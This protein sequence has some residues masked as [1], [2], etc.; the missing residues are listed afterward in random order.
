LL[1]KDKRVRLG[2]RS[3]KVIAVLTATAAGLNLA[4]TGE[5]AAVRASGQEPSRITA[6][7]AEALSRAAPAERIPVLVQMAQLSSSRPLSWD[8]DYRA[9]EH[10]S[11]LAELYSTSVA[12]L[13]SRL[14]AGLAADV[15]AGRVLWI[16]GSIAAQLTSS[17]VRM[18][19]SLPGVQRIHYDGL[20]EVELAADPTGLRLWAPGLPLAVQSLEGGLPWGLEAI[21]APELWAAGATGQGTVVAIIDSGV[22]GTHPLLW[23]KWRGNSTSPAEAWFDPWGLSATP[24]DDDF[25]AGAGHGTIVASIAVGSLEPGDTIQV[26][27]ERRVVQDEL[28]VVTGV[29][30]GAEWVAANG[31]EDLGGVTYTRS[32]VLLQAMQ[33]VLDPDGD[34]A[35]VSDVPDVLNNSWGFPPGGCDGPFDRAIDALEAAGV[36]V[37]FAAG[38]LSSGFQ[39]VAGPAERADLLLNAFAVGAVE[40][41]E[42]DIVVSDNSLGGPSRCAP[43]AVKPEVV[44]PGEIPVVRNFGPHMGIVLGNSGVFTSWASPHAAGALALLRGLNRA[45]GAG[46]LKAA[47]F[48]TAD[49]LPPPGLDN[50]SG[51]GLLDLVAAAEAIGGLGGVRLA[52]AHWTWDSTLAS[53]DLELHNRGRTPFPGGSAELRRGAGAST[54]AR[55]QAP[56]I[57]AQGRGRLTFSGTPDDLMSGPPPSLRLESDGAILD[58]PISL[59][60]A[61]ATAVVLE[62]GDARF[63]LDARGRLGRVAGDPGFELLGGDWL[64]AGAFLYGDGERVSDAA[65]VDVLQQPSLKQNPVG[66]DTDWHDVS[67]V[68]AGNGAEIDFSDDRALNP[69][70]ATIHQSV[71]LIAVGD[72]AAFAAL[73][74]RVDYERGGLPLA[75]LLLDWDLSERD[76]VFWD[77]ELGASVMTA[78]DSSGPWAALATAPRPPATHAAVPL[79]TP[80]A[81]FY[82]LGSAAGVLAKLGGFTD[83]EKAR[84][85]RLGGL[86]VSSSDIADWAQLVTV[87]PLARGE[88]M[89]FLAAFGSSRATLRLALDSARVLA[90]DG[91]GESGR[92]GVLALLPAY[93]NPFDPGAGAVISLP[94][95]TD[96]GSEP[97]VARLE[98]YTIAGRLLYSERRE[99]GPD[100]PVEPF[101]WNGLLA[102]GESAASG[103]YG[104]IIRVGRER[105]YGK[106]VVLK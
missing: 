65:Y 11:N 51:A 77:A 80:E 29:A 103:V 104:Y 15:G 39:T 33:W 86:G 17:Q 28:E 96:R 100:V 30:P 20:I 90:G 62:D 72:S 40:L 12:G 4:S 59:S 37:V 75:G 5:R 41:D 89:T 42:G 47:L 49:D 34:P 3:W 24:V 53:L 56:M 1:E 23:R 50:R 88:S 67:V 81:G 58:L 70:G 6:E 79:G 73:A 63:S 60:A 13:R 64:T 92:S 18:L 25:T 82:L 85:M 38:N 43:G 31:F 7:L 78:A 83:E 46:D 36:P 93:P 95:L 97:L 32:S 66:S 8:P 69:L 68:A 52:V 16:G 21:G 87:G 106:F 44:A 10:A 102:D 71:D 14:P 2:S 76:S 54:L 35:T 48:S 61:T 84:Y 9:A 19:E 99:Y 55:A 26:L 57:G 27:G 22:D 74:M 105:R 101:R 91:N 98:I 94:F 45:V